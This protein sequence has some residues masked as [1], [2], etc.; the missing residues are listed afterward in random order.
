MR[1]E[2]N[3]FLIGRKFK[4]IK[5]KPKIIFSLVVLFAISLSIVVYFEGWNVQ[6]VIN[7]FKD[8]LPQLLAFLIAIFFIEFWIE[9]QRLAA[10]KNL[11]QA[12]SNSIEV[13]V[14]RLALHILN[15]LSIADV[16]D[17]DK[18]ASYLGGDMSFR[19]AMLLFIQTTPA[20]IK[21]AYVKGITEAK[22]RQK[23]VDDFVELL[24]NFGG[25]IKDEV[26]KLYPV[27]DPRVRGFF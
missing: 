10:L 14:N 25:N 8:L 11:N 17:P 26:D 23:Y 21:N 5:S 6:T 12:R 27:A 16:N 20:G 15:Y 19:P 18:L 7:I 1:Y 13:S 3:P 9:R 22:D 4:Q 2:D 24:K